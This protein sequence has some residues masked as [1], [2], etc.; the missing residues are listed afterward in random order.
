[1]KKQTLLKILSETYDRVNNDECG[2]DDDELTSIATLLAHYKVNEEQVC[3]RKGIS[4]ATL[5]RRIQSG[6]YPPPHKE[7]GGKKF[8]FWDEVMDR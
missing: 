7:P 2:L 6:E 8:Y 5:T 1:M 4:R 3:H